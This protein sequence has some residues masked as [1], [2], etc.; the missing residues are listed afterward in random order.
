M[1]REVIHWPDFEGIK[2]TEGQFRSLANFPGVVGALDGCHIPILAAEYC[3][4]DNLDR[5]HNYS[6]NLMAICDSEKIRLLL[7]WI[8]RKCA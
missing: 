4:A 8:P 2:Q 6:V 1:S 5:N 3:Q 7:C